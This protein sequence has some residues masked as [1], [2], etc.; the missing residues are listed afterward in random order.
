MLVY[1]VV[2]TA[3]C[4]QTIDEYEQR[5]EGKRVCRPRPTYRGAAAVKVRWIAMIAVAGVF[6]GCK[7]DCQT[8]AETLCEASMKDYYGE[9]TQKLGEKWAEDS[10]EKCV[11]EQVL[12]CES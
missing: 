1:R 4:G 3:L 8:A 7:S 11:A 2:E 5:G 12:Q 10:L 9:V 6:L